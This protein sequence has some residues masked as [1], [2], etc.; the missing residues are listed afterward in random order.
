MREAPVR[1]MCVSVSFFAF[2]TSLLFFVCWCIFFGFLF[3]LLFLVSMD[4]WHAPSSSCSSTG[5]MG[6]YPGYGI[7][8]HHNPFVIDITT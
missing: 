8:H 7:A 1:P 3:L 4:S 5:S 2:F 6:Y